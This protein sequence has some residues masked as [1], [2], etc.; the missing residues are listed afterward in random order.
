MNRSIAWAIGLLSLGTAVY[1]GS[2]LGA[3][4]PA[5]QPP[6][7]QTRIAM[8]NLRWVIKN[9]A[10]YQSFIGEIQATEKKYIDELTARVGAG[11]NS[12]KTME[13]LQGEITAENLKSLSGGYREF[14]LNAPK[15]MVSDPAVEPSAWLVSAIKANVADVYKTI[16]KS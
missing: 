2:R 12:G 5:A 4:G 11:K 15:Y 7:T 10:K 6:A 9:Y 13:Q 8:L 16:D 1:F 14:L 3:A